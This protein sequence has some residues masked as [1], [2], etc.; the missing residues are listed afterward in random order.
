MKPDRFESTDSL[1]SSFV[2]AADLNGTRYFLI[3]RGGWTMYTDK[4]DHATT[5]GWEDVA[6]RDA[7]KENADPN[8]I[9]GWRPLLYAQAFNERDRS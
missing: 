1:F 5:Y 7:A 3:D 8:G 4:L 2:L 6:L 9:K